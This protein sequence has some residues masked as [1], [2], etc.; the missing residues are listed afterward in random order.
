[1][2]IKKVLG[3]FDTKKNGEPFISKKMV[4]YRKISVT[5]AEYGET[6]F[7]I[8][9]FKDAK[10]GQFKDYHDGDDIKG[11]AGPIRDWN[12]KKYGDWIFPKSKAKLA[13]EEIA[14][15]KRKLAEAGK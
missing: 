7:S 12:G 10:T 14:D 1:M 9:I 15:L 5:F 8:P 3:T 4:P 11:T 13:E 6:I 2:I